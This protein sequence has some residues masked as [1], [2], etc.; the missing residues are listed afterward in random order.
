[1]TTASQTR[2]LD[3]VEYWTALL[4]ELDNLPPAPELTELP[5]RSTDFG[6]VYGLR[7]TSVG[8]YRIFA[9]Y[10]V[11]HGEG[12]FP[13]LYYLPR[14]GSVNQLPPYEQRQRYICVQLCHRGQR[15][16]DQP[17]AAAYPGLLTTDIDDPARYVYRG[18]VA[19]CCRVVDFL[20]SR[21]EVDGQR[22]ALLG[23]DLALITA[24]LRPQVDALYCTPGLFYAAA[25]LAPRTKAYPLEE[26]NDYV[27]THPDQAERV[28]QTLSYFDPIH[29]APQVQA[30]TVLVTG[31]ER[32]LFSPDVLA[33][34]VS[35]M[36]GA[37]TP[38]VS[39]HSSYQDGVRQEAWLRARYGFAEPLLPPHWRS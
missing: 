38:Y 28:W 15:L 25:E 10:C 9:Y 35:A 36:G 39:A 23:D 29:F 19:D 5:L 30:E 27:R 37:V 2:P 1:M 13:V 4:A 24:A 6:T 20:Q 22:I 12:P 8:P 31:N 21:P 26:L 11:P 17:F 16:A 34:L 32:D 14:Y 33:P 3:F 18:I 7:L